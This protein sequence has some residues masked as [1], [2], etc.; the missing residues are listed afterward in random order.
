MKRLVLILMLLISIV[1]FGAAHTYD[2]EAMRRRM[3]ELSDSLDEYEANKRAEKANRLVVGKF[4]VIGLLVDDSK[5]GLAYKAFVLEDSNTG[6]IYFY[7]DIEDDD[8]S[9][10]MNNNHVKIDEN[11][12]DYSYP[13]SGGEEKLREQLRKDDHIIL[14]RTEFN[15]KRGIN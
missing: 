6:I 5:F 13:Y 2:A 3:Y 11:K 15:K 14:S 1:N 7:D 8:V 9:E 12:V 10:Y 4:T